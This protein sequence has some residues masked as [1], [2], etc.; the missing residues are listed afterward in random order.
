MLTL[1]QTKDLLQIIKTLNDRLSVE[2][3]H[4]EALFEDFEGFNK[5]SVKTLD[6]LVDYA[7]KYLGNQGWMSWWVFEC[8]FGNNP[9]EA[10]AKAGDPLVK[11]DSVEVLYELILGG[12]ND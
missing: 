2:R 4:Y 6:N 8:D 7:D 10:S 12:A 11:V 3:A 9:M 5:T 1:Q